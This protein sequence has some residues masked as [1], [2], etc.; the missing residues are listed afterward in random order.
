MSRSSDPSELAGGSVVSTPHLSRWL[1]WGSAAVFLA[2]C[3]A[4]LLLW[5]IAGPSYLLDLVA[6]YCA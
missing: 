1:L 2:L 3:L 5:G 4:I 6:A